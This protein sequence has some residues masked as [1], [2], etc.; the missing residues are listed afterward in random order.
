MHTCTH[1][2]VGALV[3][4]PRLTAAWAPCIQA[5]SASIDRSNS[6]CTVVAELHTAYS[7]AVRV[8]LLASSNAEAHIACLFNTPD[9]KRIV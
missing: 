6:N 9:Q 8:L 5:Q 7:V 1:A 3:H 2:H 4:T